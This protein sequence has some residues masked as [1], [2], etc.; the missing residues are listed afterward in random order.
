MA[1]G[2]PGSAIL[3]LRRSN[4]VNALSWFPLCEWHRFAGI[5]PRRPAELAGTAAARDPDRRTMAAMS[6]QKRS[7]KAE[8]YR[9]LRLLARGGSDGD[10]E[11][12]MLAHG[13]TISMLGRLV[14]D[15]L[16]TATPD[17][18]LAGSRPIKVVRVQITDA[19]R[20]ALTG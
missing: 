17:T 10:T 1:K 6:A 14:F 5:R 7:L 3:L 20:R 11:A 18:V 16:V 13:F 9:A 4:R 15:G 12:I 2:R 8:Q 19:G